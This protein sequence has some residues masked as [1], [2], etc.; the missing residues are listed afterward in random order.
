MEGVVRT[1]DPVWNCLDI[2][3]GKASHGRLTG[4]GVCA[5]LEEHSSPMALDAGEEGSFFSSEGE[6]EGDRQA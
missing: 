1:F 3:V 6:A 4:G 2:N 5:I